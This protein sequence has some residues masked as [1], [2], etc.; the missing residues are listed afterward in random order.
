MRRSVFGGVLVLVLAAAAAGSAAAQ[1]TGTPIFKA[2][3]RTFENHEF[4]GNLS[5]PGSGV[6]YALEGF[7]S[8]GYERFDIG[9]RG[10][11]EKLSDDLGH[12][13]LIGVHAR[14]RVLNASDRF[15]LDGALVVG[16]G[17]NLGDGP[18]AYYV[19]IG[20]S[21]G[22]RFAVENS[23]ITIV[24][25]VQPTLIPVFGGGNSNLDFSLGLGVD[26]RLS[27]NFDFRLSGGI[28]DVDGIGVGLAF[29]R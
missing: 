6:A 29:I 28:G 3:Y 17:A 15:P 18:D 9:I 27:R 24:P 20:I 7:Y 25:Y 8:F 16:F 12:R 4:G 11:Y 1:E 2:P 26:I 22:R 21:L 5:D 10:G 13:A 23:S 14:T 19:P